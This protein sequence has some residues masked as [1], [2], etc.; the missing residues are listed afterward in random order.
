MNQLSYLGPHFVWEHMENDGK[1]LREK[2]ME[3]NHGLV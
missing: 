1:T 3:N 2:N